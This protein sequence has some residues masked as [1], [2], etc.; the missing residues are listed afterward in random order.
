MQNFQ[1]PHP[2]PP[3]PILHPHFWRVAIQLK[4]TGYTW[5]IFNHFYKGDNF[6]CTLGPFWKGVF[7]KRKEFAPKGAN[8]FLSEKTPSKKEIEQILSI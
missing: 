2:P 7:S 1:S 5:L 4:G 8:S 6:S 3:T